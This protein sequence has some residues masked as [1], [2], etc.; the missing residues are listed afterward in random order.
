M[1]CFTTLS[2][3]LQQFLKFNTHTEQDPGRKRENASLGVLGSV[4]SVRRREPGAPGLGLPP[5]VRLWRQSPGQNGQASPRQRAVGSGACGAATV[6]GKELAAR[7][8]CAVCLEEVAGEEPARVVLGCRHGFHQEC[9][10]AWLARRSVCPVCMAK[11]E[12]QSWAE[13][14]GDHQSPC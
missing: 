2:T 13:E 14:A 5:Q 12:P 1:A 6:T 7:T 9:A 8:E 10:D 3:Y 4:S 11:L